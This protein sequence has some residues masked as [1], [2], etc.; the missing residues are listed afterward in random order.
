VAAYME[1]QETSKYINGLNYSIQELVALQNMFSVDKAY[2]KTMNIER[3]QRRVL[4][5]KRTTERTSS[6]T[7]AH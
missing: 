5:F 6:N 2:N 3:L 1:E 4:P 7:R